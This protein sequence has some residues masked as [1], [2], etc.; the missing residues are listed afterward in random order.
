MYVD[1][2]QKCRDFTRA[3][4]V[5]EAGYYPYFRAIEEN[6]GP[7]VRIEGREVI[8]AGS[9]NYLGL[10]G[11]PRV[12]EAAKQAIDQYG[13]SCS[14][15]RYL[16]GTVSLHEE[17]ER[18]LADYMGKEACLLF[19]TGYQTAQGVIP[20][21]VGRGDYVISDRDNHACIVAANLMAKGA[22]GE[23]V[24]Y[25]HGDM[26]DLERRMSKLPE[27]A[28]KLIVTDGV[29]STT[30]TIVDLP[31]L[32]EIAKKYGARM[33]V[34]DAH[35][36]G[37]I[38]KGGRGTASHFGLEDETDLTMGTF[39]KSLA[40][41]GGWVVGDERVINY[42]KHTSPAL[43]FSASPT[44]ASVASAIEALKIIREEP[45]RIERLKSNADYLRNGFKEMGYKVI[46]GVTGVIPVIVGDDTLA[47]IFW[48]RLFDAGV[49]VNA[50]ITPGVMQGYQMMRCSVMATHEKE[51]LDTIL[52]LFEDIGT[53]MGLLDKETGSVAAE[54]SR[55]DDENVQSQPLP[56]DGDV[57]IREVSGRKGNKE[58][59]RMVW[60][61]HKDEENWIAPI[62]M[63]RMRLID[64]QKNPFYKHAEIKLFLAE[65]GGEPV[66]RIAAIVNHIH[67]RTYDDKLG[68]FGFFESV[69]DQNVA[70]ALLNAAT[71]WLREKGMNAI[72]GPVSPSTNDEVGLLIKGFEHIPS[73]LM[74][75]NPP[76]YL[77]LLE[78]AGFE[79]EKKLLAWH[80][81][82]PEC[83]TDKIVR[84]T[85][86]LK[87]RGKIRIRS[88][89]MKKF[90]DEVENI[91]RIYNEAWQP[92]WGFVPMNDEEM[93]TLAYEL[94]QIMDPDLVVFAEKEG[95]DS[96]IGFALAVPNI[97]QALRKGKPIPPGAKNLPTAIMNLM[98]N[99]KKIDA[100]RIITLGVLPKY[101]AK[102]IDAML[103]RELME[104][105]VAKG[106]EK[107]EASWV[108]EDNTM[109]NRAAEMMNA[110]AYK[111]YGVYEKSL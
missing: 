72:R 85:A 66:G 76:Y 104:Q 63:D 7:V 26:D 73:A 55:E 8:M 33:M 27:D 86:A 62:E 1:I 102:G 28:G 69:N 87:Q 64:T 25:K 32:T 71:D 77:E 99:K 91:K 58:F 89:N 14:G 22:F 31:R 92:N 59:V 57:S 12:M 5:K 44:P 20:S 43:I 24:R 54:E 93:N 15:S 60:R 38:G 45:Q 68:F 98:T 18:E 41:L 100:M 50:F 107:G 23:V 51:H 78:N 3:D 95:E 40:S 56:V 49:F 84:V 39:S 103:Y 19:S 83:M 48:R 13:T 106:M 2:F 109:M 110:E 70:N 61:L 65:R 111:V 53:Q 80:V 105:G 101:Q 16:T 82:Y 94:K 90:P 67:N 21:L 74:P 79:L 35:A 6:E 37:V 96:P 36:L 4:D 47:F 46:E 34:D 52:H 30:G 10:T 11:H 75:W 88:L 42:I 9:N 17:L 97:N 29:F 108:L 81:Q